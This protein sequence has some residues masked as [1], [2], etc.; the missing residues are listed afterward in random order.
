MA[1]VDNPLR[2]NYRA[3]IDGLRAIAVLA[4][5]L[6][7][8]RSTWL[9]GGFIGVDIF[10]VISGFVVASALSQ[11]PVNSFGQFILQFYARRLA[12]IIPALVFVLT[13]TAL[14]ASLFIPRAW[15]SGLSEETALFAFWG[16]SNW[17]LQSNTDFYFAPRAEFNPYTQTWSLGVEEQFYVL[18]PM[19]F[20]LWV[21]AQQRQQNRL[22]RSA[23]ILLGILAF[24][25][26]VLCAWATQHDPAL[27]F[28]F[29]GARFWELA[30][31]AL[32][33]FI[34]TMRQ[35]DSKVWML[36]SIGV[37]LLPWCGVFIIM[38]AFIFTQTSAFPWPW[39]FVAC[40]GTLC[41]LGGVGANNTH[42]VRRALAHPSLVW[43]GRRSYSLYL[44]HW[45]VFVLLR[46][47]TG[48][49]TVSQYGG[50][51]ILT[52]LLAMLTYRFVEQPL[53]HN[54]W[55]ERRTHGLVISFFLLLPLAGSLT[56]YYFFSHLERVSLSVVSRTPNDWYGSTLSI[57]SQ[58][59]ARPCAVEQEFVSFFGGTERI[60]RPKHCEPTHSATSNTATLYV[61]GDSHAG[62]IIP[63]LEQTSATLGLTIRI[64]SFQGAVATPYACSY[65]DL[66][67]PM[68]F[69]RA[70]GCVEF[71]E[72]VRE[73][74]Q[75][76]AK[77]EDVV[78]LASLRMPRYGDQWASFGIDN[79][80]A[81]I[82]S[83]DARA[84]REAASQQIPAWL[85]PLLRD[86]VRV[87][88]MAPTPVFQA[89]TFRCADWFN[90]NNPICIGKNQ[91]ARLELEQLRQPIIVRMQ[92][93]A[94]DNPA[95]LVWDPFAVLCPGD[96]CNAVVDGKPFF[97]DGD[98][99]SNYGNWILYPH[100]L[101]W[102][103][104]NRLLQ[105]NG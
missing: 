69:G 56:S 65:L 58:G 53:R 33:F 62:A 98:H 13:V 46:W 105:P 94:E 48:L 102:L 44:W 18:A 25:S 51:L 5:I 88:F 92:K 1:P 6:Y 82:D 95:V 17:R 49:E 90:A 22:R 96:T 59:S 40:L 55:V 43:L 11:N 64:F 80:Q 104:Q 67:A 71:N 77:P 86:G 14:L 23:V 50:G 47:T 70:P 63:L 7:H 54:A 83:A 8:L 24:A 66:Q 42:P 93:L 97:F 32:L 45:P 78:L 12:R 91:Q 81:K 35:Q 10:F 4:V 73:R 31:G 34:S 99:L 16:L 87:V 60:L 26:L 28:Y 84:L 79:M 15:L 38:L 41:I 9:P 76:H 68:D 75:S 52:V 19:L 101:E 20:F 27:A 30:C 74:V 57:Y 72:A 21:Y 39:A 37:L 103:R 89:P 2:L 36:P 61:L 85:S 29:I 3:D 100:F